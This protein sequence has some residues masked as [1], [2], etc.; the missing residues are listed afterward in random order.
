MSLQTA[1]DAV[2]AKKNAYNGALNGCQI[3][4]DEPHLSVQGTPPTTTFAVSFTSPDNDSTETACVNAQGELN[5]ALAQ[6]RVAGGT[7]TL[8]TGSNP[9]TGAPTAVV[10]FTN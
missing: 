1:K 8:S 3:D 9:A 4:E 10:T 5:S 6:L 7:Y 2:V